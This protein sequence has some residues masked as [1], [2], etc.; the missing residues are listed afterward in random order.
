MK[1]TRQETDQLIRLIDHSRVSKI[2]IESSSSLASTNAEDALT[3]EINC[4]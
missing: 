3:G 1:T 4:S 2:M